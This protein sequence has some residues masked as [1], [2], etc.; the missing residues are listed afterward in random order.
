[1]NLKDFLFSSDYKDVAED[2]RSYPTPQDRKERKK[3]LKASI[4]CI[5]VS[6][7]FSERDVNH[8][9]EPSGLI[10]V[11]MDYADN[12]DIAA[13]I[14]SIVKGL[15]YVLFCSRSITDR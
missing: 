8:L 11:D 13:E 5:T 1:M 10:C 6:G 3:A 14:P 7:R 2:I 15:D 4:P 9:I 12:A